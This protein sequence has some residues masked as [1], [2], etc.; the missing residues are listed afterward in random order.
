MEGPFVWKNR[1]QCTA[2]LQDPS[3]L[4]KHVLRIVEMLEE[5]I[6]PNEVEGRSL[7]WNR[8]SICHEETWRLGT[9]RLRDCTCVVQ[10]F[11]IC[12]A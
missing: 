3:H 2:W 1:D 6:A 12:S 4:C 5:A 7:K 9:D 8:K 11:G 10:V